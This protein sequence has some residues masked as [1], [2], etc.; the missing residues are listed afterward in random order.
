M[1][2]CARSGTL[3][4]IHLRFLLFL[5]CFPGDAGSV[6]TD[7]HA[8]TPV[9]SCAAF[10]VSVALFPV[11]SWNWKAAVLSMTIRCVALFCLVAR[12][13]GHS[14]LR[15]AAIEAI[16]VSFTAG[17]WAAVQQRAL[18]VRPRWL[19]N[20]LVVAAVPALAQWVDYMV[21]HS[22]GTPGM[23]AASLSLFTWGLFSAS[24]H[25]HLMRHGALLVGDGS[26]SFVSDLRR[27]P[28]LLLSFASGPIRLLR[29]TERVP[30][31]QT[32]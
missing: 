26:R 16:Y 30:L 18:P 23:R 15:A 24:L 25:L 11:R 8:P 28:R 20:L 12:Q 9:R 21:Q 3:S 2:Q 5:S 27:L 4:R 31:E 19:S 14:G 29:R 10:L 6:T 13:G 7:N 1:A 32:S 17:T 22:L